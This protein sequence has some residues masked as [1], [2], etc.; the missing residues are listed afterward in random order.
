MARRKSGI[1]ARLSAIHSRCEF[2]DEK[3]TDYYYD[4]HYGQLAMAHQSIAHSNRFAL[5]VKTHASWSA[6]RSLHTNELHLMTRTA[7]IL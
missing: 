4:A 5:A 2:S 6:L 1:S 7:C 3:N